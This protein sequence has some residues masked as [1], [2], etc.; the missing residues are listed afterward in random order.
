MN[1]TATPRQAVLTALITLVTALKPTTAI[2]QQL[3]IVKHS[4]NEITLTWRPINLAPQMADGL[5]PDYTVDASGDLQAWTPLS[6]TYSGDDITQPDQARFSTSSSTH[7]QS[8]SGGNSLAA[9]PSPPAA[10]EPAS[11]CMS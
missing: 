2:D 8:N 6:R 1:L 5:A 7:S 3:A 9:P 11:Q 4:D 10:N